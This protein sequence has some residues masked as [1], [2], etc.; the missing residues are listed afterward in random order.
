MRNKDEI[1]RLGIGNWWCLDV[2]D[3]IE[4]CENSQRLES[5]FKSNQWSRIMN[6]IGSRVSANQF[7]DG[8]GVLEWTLPPK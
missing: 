8:G 1:E 3:S 2:F 7:Y 4:K 6:G 5:I